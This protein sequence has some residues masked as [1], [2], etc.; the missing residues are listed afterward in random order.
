M[1]KL[2]SR[3]DLSSFWNK[4]LVELGRQID[5]ASWYSQSLI[6]VAEAISPNT[7]E[8]VAKT[9]LI[10]SNSRNSDPNQDPQK[11]G[12]AINRKDPVFREV[13]KDLCAEITE[14]V[15]KR[16]GENWRDIV[17]QLASAL[18]TSLD[19]LASEFGS[20]TAGWDAMVRLKYELVQTNKSVQRKTDWLISVVSSVERAV[21]A[22]TLMAV[23]YLGQS[24]KFSPILTEIV[25]EMKLDLG[26]ELLPNGDNMEQQIRAISSYM[27]AGITQTLEVA[28]GLIMKATGHQNQEPVFHEG[29]ENSDLPALLECDSSWPS[30][31]KRIVALRDKAL[32]DDSSS[33]LSMYMGG[34]SAH[35]KDLEDF[36]DL[37]RSSLQ[38]I[39]EFM[40]AVSISRCIQ[41]MGVIAEFSEVDTETNSEV[42]LLR[43]KAASELRVRTLDLLIDKRFWLAWCLADATNENFEISNKLMLEINV[44]FARK[45][46]ATAYRMGDL[47]DVRCV[48]D[49]GSNRNVRYLILRKTLLG[50]FDGIDDL[51]M[52]A[53]VSKNMSKQEF[54]QWPALEDLRAIPSFAHVLAEYD[55]QRQI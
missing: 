45:K 53:L 4:L 41:L 14:V 54:Y 31:F 16:H 9:L 25:G 27:T 36:S 33:D 48:P 35:H 38:T 8:L 28:D 2:S 6:D 20:T 1:K 5:D 13:Y 34:I 24:P 47:F 51:I 39:L 42:A 3:D 18:D 15:L 29:F 52:S 10:R 21:R 32:H 11:Q 22:N 46:L 30:V 55:N 37:S 49:L 50:Q 23:Q 43:Y 7:A 12:E 17:P 40:F 26:E 44:A 19:D